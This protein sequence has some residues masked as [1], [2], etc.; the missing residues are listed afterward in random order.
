MRGPACVFV[1]ANVPDLSEIRGRL[2]REAGRW[3]SNQPLSKSCE[4]SARLDWK[5]KMRREEALGHHTLLL[6][7]LTGDRAAVI[8]HWRNSHPL[9]GWVGMEEATV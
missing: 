1:S 8:K 9:I 5:R 6:L 2:A 4:G 3:N 7:P